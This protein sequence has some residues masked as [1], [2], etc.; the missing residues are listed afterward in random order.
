M[1]VNRYEYIMQNIN[2]TYNI[3]MIKNISAKLG[4]D[5]LETICVTFEY[6]K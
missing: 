1:F 3:S 6:A 2:R 4:V 5:E